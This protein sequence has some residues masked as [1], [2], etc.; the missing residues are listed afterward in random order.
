MEAHHRSYPFKRAKSTNE[1]SGMRKQIKLLPLFL[2]AAFLRQ[3]LPEDDDD[4]D[5]DVD[6]VDVDVDLINGLIVQVVS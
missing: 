3:I 4:D 6:D 2:S 1:C 5:D